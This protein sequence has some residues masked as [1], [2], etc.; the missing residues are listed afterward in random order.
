MTT[1]GAACRP[2]HIDL[3]V[4]G[5]TAVVLVGVVAISQMGGGF[6][7]DPVPYLFAVGFGA[8]LMLRRRMPITVLTLSVLGTFA[9]YAL[10]HPPIG[11]A[12]PVFAALYSTAEAGLTRWVVGAGV[13]VLVASLYFRLREAL[14]SPGYVLGTDTMSN[15][16]LVAAAVA[17]GYGSRARAVRAAREREIAELTAAQHEREVELRIRR[18][19]EDLS[20]ELHDTLGHDL[21]VIALHAGVGAEAVGR[22]DETVAT[23]IERIRQQSTRSLQELRRLVRILRSDPTRHEVRVL[24]SR[25]DLDSLVTRIEEAA[26]RVRSDVTLSPGSVPVAV[27]AAAFRIVQEALTNVLRHAEASTVRVR[28]A[29]NGDVLRVVVEDDGRGV[30]GAGSTGF[31]L[32]GMTDRVRLL[33]G[34]VQTASGPGGGFTVEAVIP[35]EPRS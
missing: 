4:S 22:D 3:V 29:R 16:A 28:A 27:D 10:D 25:S 23:A 24:S 1:T 20:R 5:V 2:G 7:P 12:L 13:V 8:V 32:S 17:L 30:S 18:E 26:I 11:V 6:P 31:G 33:G 35:A 14:P 9:Y 34:T 19:R 21:S 15:A